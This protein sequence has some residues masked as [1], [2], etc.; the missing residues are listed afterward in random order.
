VAQ[1][2]T[3]KIRTRIKA[4]AAKKPAKKK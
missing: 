3:M 2:S 4:G 1:E